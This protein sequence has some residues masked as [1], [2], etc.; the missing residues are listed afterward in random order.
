MQHEESL[1]LP[2]PNHAAAD[3]PALFRQEIRILLVCDLIY[4]HLHAGYWTEGR[5][6]QVPTYLQPACSLKCVKSI[7]LESNT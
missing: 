2:L 1:I 5:Q 7:I 3:S 4:F 6:P